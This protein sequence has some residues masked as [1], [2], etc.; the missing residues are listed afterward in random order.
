[1]V[2]GQRL[3]RLPKIAQVFVRDA[4]PQQPAIVLHHGDA[5]A[6]IR[7]IDHDVH[8]AVARKDITQ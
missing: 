4:D 1:M 6:A 3:N 5:G 2:D 8:G 7:R